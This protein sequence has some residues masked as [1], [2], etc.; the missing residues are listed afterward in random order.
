MPKSGNSVLSF[1]ASVLSLIT[2][3]V[4]DGENTLSPR[5]RQRQSA[6]VG[7]VTGSVG[8]GRPVSDVALSRLYFKVM[9]LQLLVLLLYLAT[10]ETVHD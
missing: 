10:K 9:I 2:K 8:S 1:N 6:D 7:G 4:F 3:D 5:C